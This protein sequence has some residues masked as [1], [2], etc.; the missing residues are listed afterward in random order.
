MRQGTGGEARHPRFWTSLA[1]LVLCSSLAACGGSTKQA[2]N[3]QGGGAGV[4]PFEEVT[5]FDGPAGD[6]PP[7]ALPRYFA[8]EVDGEGQLVLGLPVDLDALAHQAA[9]EAQDA[10]NVGAAVVVTAAVPRQRVTAVVDLLLDAGFSHLVLSSRGGAWSKLMPSASATE[11]A[12]ATSAEVP[13]AETLVE[14]EIAPTTPVPESATLEDIPTNV[15]VKQ[16]GVH[17]GGGPNTEEA[18]A[19]YADPISKR[20]DEFKRCYPLAQGAGRNASFGVDLLINSRG[21]TAKIKDYRTAL[22]GKDFHLCVLGVFG[23]IEF[24]APERATVVSYSL[25]F[26]PL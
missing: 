16:M 24:P 19:A 3:P 11:V 26:K 22:G 10:R 23:T 9:R 21:G 1:A 6:Q 2:E 8:V 15:E 17:I 14:P 5:G 12:G 13:E 20:F 25:L 4:T 18:H 7:T